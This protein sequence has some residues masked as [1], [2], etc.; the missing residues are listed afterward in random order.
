L[1]NNISIFSFLK[2]IKNGTPV[3]ALAGLVIWLG[4]YC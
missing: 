2:I 1:N 3:S 4:F